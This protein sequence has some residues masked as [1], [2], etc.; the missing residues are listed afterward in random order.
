MRVEGFRG[1][2]EL[3]EFWRGEAAGLLRGF[4]QD[5]FPARVAFFGGGEKRFVGAI[6]GK[7]DDFGGAQFGG[8][9]EA[10]FEAVEFDERDE[11]SETGALERRLRPAR[12]ARIR[13][14]FRRASEAYAFNTSE[15][16]GGAVAQFVELAGFGAQDAAR[17][18]A[19]SPW[20][21]AESDSNLSTKKRR[22]IGRL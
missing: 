13:C 4:M 6:S 8:F 14:D 9:F 19:V 20:R 15:P 2:G 18:S 10:P 7:R 12:R 17:C 21:V 5:F 1:R 3:M 22:R 16:D 11:Q